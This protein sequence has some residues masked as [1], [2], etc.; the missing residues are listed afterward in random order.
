MS[1][2]TKSFSDVKCFI[3]FDDLEEEYFDDF[4]NLVISTLNAKFIRRDEGPYADLVTV[5]YEGSSLI[6][7]SGS[8][9]GCFI[10]IDKDKE[11]LAQE[12]I[13]MFIDK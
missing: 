12:L 10:S 5:E 4:V 8:Y 7:S 1:R 6:L 11:Q 13:D 2:L 3:S 9:E